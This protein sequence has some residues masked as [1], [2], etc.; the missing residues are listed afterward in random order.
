VRIA[1]VTTSYPSADWP[2]D[3]SGHFI[4][5]ERAVLER[6]GHDVIVIAPTAR[7]GGAFGWPGVVARVRERPHR[8][9]EAATWILRARIELARADRAK[10][11]DR[12]IAHWALPSAWPVASIARGDGGASRVEI[13]SHGGDVRL[14]AAMPRMLRGALVNALLHHARAWRFVSAPL[15]D[16]LLEALDT[17]LRERVRGIA[18]VRPSPLEMPDVRHEA[19]AIRREL[20]SSD[21]AR[22]AVTVARLVKSKRVDHVI[23]HAAKTSSRLIVVGDGPERAALE[24]LA[25]A[26]GVD[27][28]FVGKVTRPRALAFIAA[29]DVLVHASRHEGLSTVIR[30]AEA[31][32]TRVERLA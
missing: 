14:V 7:P 16:E 18:E 20:G 25:R 27:A 19:A 8:A 3:P 5:A 30:E 11:F 1:I 12:I 29:A 9:L 2:G 4:H 13:V 15:R 17:E 10:R 22:V 26:R 21:R 23:E 32:G 28:R 31:L 24:L 6:E